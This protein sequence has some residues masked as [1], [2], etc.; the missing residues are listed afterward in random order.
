MACKLVA[1]GESVLENSKVIKFVF[2]E[3]LKTFSYQMG[4]DRI[5]SVLY[6]IL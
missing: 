6:L 1:V 3:G 5:L 4:I 2:Y